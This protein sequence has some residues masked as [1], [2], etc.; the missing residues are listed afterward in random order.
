MRSVVMP[1]WCKISVILLVIVSL[2]FYIIS[3]CITQTIQFNPNYNTSGSQ[4]NC[5]CWFSSNWS[6]ASGLG[7]GRC[8]LWPTIPWTWLPSFS[9][10]YFWLLPIPPSNFIFLFISS[11]RS[12]IIEFKLHLCWSALSWEWNYASA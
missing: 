11:L 8:L 7:V 5:S 9:T 10:F 6:P 2:Q 12:R 4:D 3:I 1:M